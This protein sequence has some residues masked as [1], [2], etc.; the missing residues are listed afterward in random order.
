MEEKLDRILTELQN[1]NNRLEKLETGQENL[2]AGQGI[3]TKRLE[4]LEKV[5]WIFLS[6]K[7]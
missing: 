6:D 4:T 1:T 2:V 7:M 3:I 5:K